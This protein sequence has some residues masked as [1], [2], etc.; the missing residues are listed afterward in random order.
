MDA[1]K[2]HLCA[3]RSLGSFRFLTER[4]WRS[5]IG[6]SASSRF[7]R[8]DSGNG[9]NDLAKAPGTYTVTWISVAMGIV[10]ENSQAAI[11]RTTDKTIK[12]SSVVTFTAPYKGGWVAIIVKK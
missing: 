5:I 4:F 10:V 1:R 9:L 7:H 12:G 11:N 2:G 8:P 6:G 3:D